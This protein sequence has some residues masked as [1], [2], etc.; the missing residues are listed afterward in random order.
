[1]AALASSAPC[2][3]RHRRPRRSST[4]RC[5]RVVARARAVRWAGYRNRSTL[6]RAYRDVRQGAFCIL[7]RQPAY[8]HLAD[9]ALG[10]RR[11]PALSRGLPRRAGAF[12]TGVAFVTTMVAGEPVGLIVNSSPPCRS[13][14]LSSR[15]A[16]HAHRS[17]GRACGAGR[18]RVNILARQHERSSGSGTGKRRPVHRAPLETTV[19]SVHW[20]LTPIA[21]TGMRVKPYHARDHSDRLRTWTPC[22]PHGTMIR[23]CF[24]Q[25][26]PRPPVG[27]RT[28]FIGIVHNAPQGTRP[29][30]W[31]LL[32]MSKRLSRLVAALTL[33]LLPAVAAG[34][35]GPAEGTASGGDGS[36]GSSRSLRTRRRRRPTGS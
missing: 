11:R 2:S 15:S 34:C 25:G 14:R 9:V 28:F 4:S 36:A 20:S 3:L 13:S 27:I 16:R 10:V 35:G 21:V 23:S 19:R 6:A 8:D 24:S 32:H 18:L 12:A 17:R 5:P 29:N 22:G 30:R 7:S 31:R 26:I 1:M 33:L